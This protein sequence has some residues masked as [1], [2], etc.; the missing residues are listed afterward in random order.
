MNEKQFPLGDTAFFIKYNMKGLS[1]LAFSLLFHQVTGQGISSILDNSTNP[2]EV[3]MEFDNRSP[4]IKGIFY[5]FDEW[6]KGQFTL[7]SGA[8]IS[9]QWLNY[10]VEY[11]LLEVK[12]DNEV[13]IVPLLMLKGFSTSDPGQEQTYYLPCDNYYYEQKV[14]LTGLC[15][16]VESDYYGLI[17]R[18]I[19]DIKESTYIPALDIGNKEDELI[20]REKL[21]LTI[22]DMAIEIPQKKQSF[23]HLYP[24]RSM[25][26]TSFIKEHKLN[27][28]NVSD[29]LIILNFLNEN[30]TFQ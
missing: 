21:Y 11:D 3:L 24:D 15:E 10:D 14:P 1:L 23:I 19:T 5:L 27:H 28:R 29:L 2:G 12:L 22:G 16:V 30:N 25:D 7:N 17:M 4:Q 20:I 9:E 13:K 6:Q 8:S 18:F 26:L